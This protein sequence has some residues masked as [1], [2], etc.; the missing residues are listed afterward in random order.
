MIRF[1]LKSTVL[2]LTLAA[3]IFL[4]GVRQYHDEIDLGDRIVSVI[5]KK[6]DSF[7]RVVEKLISQK[8]IESRFAIKAVARFTGVDKRLTPGRYDFGGKN[9]AKSVLERLAEGDFLRIKV[10]IPEGSTIWETARMV[11]EK[12]G[13][14]STAIIDLSRDSILLS[15]LE[16]PC[17]EGYLFP[18]TYF[19][20]WG[21]SAEEVV[22][23]MVNNFRDLT[24][25]IWPS[26]IV[27]ELNRH[28]VIILASIVEAETGL[29][30]ER[31][32]VSS[33][34]NNRISRN[35][36]LDADPT[37]IYGLGGLNRPLWTKDLKKDTPYNTYL[38][39]GLPPTPIN[40]P[41]LAAIRAALHP[42]RSDYLFFVADK[43]GGHRF[44]KTIAEHNRAIKEIRD[45][46]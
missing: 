3:V 4:I 44:S 6:G 11:S 20:P 23:E 45:E 41:G 12:M 39:K 18:E 8:V 14:D 9:S 15:R 43:S 30:S 34:Y 17:L 1:L 27:N 10:T 16:L 7:G 29:G 33:V 28:E 42:D 19:F 31:S 13:F 22:T 24:D 25:T 38:H 5:V 21:Y 40:S 26:H 36:K 2:L 32:M 46:R 35:M 37:V